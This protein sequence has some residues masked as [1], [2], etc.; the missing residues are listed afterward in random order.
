[1]PLVGKQ[2]Q[3][4]AVLVGL[5]PNQAGVSNQFSVSSSSSLVFFLDL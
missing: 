1:M 2:Q 5:L 4:P 3:N